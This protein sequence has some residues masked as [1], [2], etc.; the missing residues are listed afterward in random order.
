MKKLLSIIFILIPA[1]YSSAQL[2]VQPDN[3]RSIIQLAVRY[4]NDKNYEK[5]APL[6]KEILNSADSRPYFPLYITCLIELQDYNDA[7]KLIQ[8]EIKKARYP[9]SELYVNWGQL[10][11][12]QKQEAEADQKFDLAVRSVAN[13]RPAYISTANSFMRLGNFEYAKQTYLE[14]EK[15][16]PG[17]SFDY[18]LA[19]IY[20]YLRDY[21]NMMVKYL[22]YLKSDDN[23]LPQVESIVGSTLNRDVDDELTTEFRSM[24][25][26]RIHADPDVLVYN[27]FFI[28]FL[29][30]EQDFS[31]ALQ[32]AVAL[33][34]RTGHE[35]SE[36]YDL[37]NIA[38]NNRKYDAARDAYE[39]LLEKGNKNPYYLGSF[40]Q[41]L[42]IS[43][44]ILKDKGFNN[45]EQELEL[46]DKFKTGL[47]YLKNIP[48]SYWMVK[49]Y[50]HL[51]AFY[52]KQPDKAIQELKTGLTLRGLRPEQT[53]ELKTEM[54]DI[55]VYSGD[56][57]EATLIYSQ[58]IEANK[59]NTL[60]DEVKLKKARLSYYLGDFAW[61]QAQLD[62]IKAS[63]SKLTSNDAFEL[64]LL[65]GNNSK[66]DSTN[67]PLKMFSHADL[68]FFRN[69]DSLAVMTLDSIENLYP[70][71]SL[72]DDVLFRKA[73]INLKNGKIQEAVANLEKIITDFS[74]DSLADDALFLLADT[75]QFRLKDTVKAQ[76]YYK[77]LLVDHPGS[78]FVVESRKRYRELRGDSTEDKDMSDPDDN[79]DNLFFRGL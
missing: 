60:G 59:N 39:Y 71:H 62:V 75:Y 10:L 79:L 27:K 9:V 47:D 23:R 76:E 50:A 49:E 32:Q 77:K 48:D 34:R 61:A 29:L 33:D 74:Y 11:L 16:L 51:L 44:L 56:P 7:E 65:I 8:K 24:V 14:G 25:L 58:V 36:I 31:G 67:V 30:K 20:Y 41:N 26:R 28:W 19:R 17:T 1:L 2:Q 68:L 40:M 45:K 42:Q 3:R 43:Y 53:G 46:A 54:A 37:A 66:P 6:L 70:N 55:Y 78:I 69:E 5:A 12:A 35:D 38:A 13:N 22:D 57:W 15:N 72:D 4:Y 21:Q 52:L 18:E 73:K 64:S 63:T